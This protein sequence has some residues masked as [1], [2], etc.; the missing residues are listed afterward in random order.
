[1]GGEGRRGPERKERIGK[2]REEEVGQRVTRERK[3]RTHISE[4]F[5][6]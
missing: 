2:N 4:G 1:M 6:F 5:S 3:S